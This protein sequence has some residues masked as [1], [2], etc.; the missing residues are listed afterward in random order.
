[1]DLF[2]NAVCRVCD[3]AQV[4]I[5][6][7]I[8]FSDPFPSSGRP[9]HGRENMSV[10]LRL[11][12][13]VTA[14]VCGLALSLCIEPS[15][16]TAQSVGVFQRDDCTTITSPVTG[17]TYCYDQTANTLKKWNGV[18][19]VGIANERHAYRVVDD[20][21]RFDGVEVADAA[22][23]SGKATVI[24]AT[25]SC[26]VADANRV[27]WVYGAG[28]GNS[29]LST[30]VSSCS[31]PAF[32]LATRASTTVTNARFIYGSDDTAAIQTTLNRLVQG[33]DK[34]NLNVELPGGITFI[35]AGLS[36]ANSVS[37]LTLYGAG[38]AGTKIYWNGAADATM[39]LLQR[40]RNVTVRDFSLHGKSTAIPKYG[41]EVRGLNG[42]PPGPGAIGTPAPQYVIIDGMWIGSM[43][44][45]SIQRAV[46]W[47]PGGLK[48][49]TDG[50]MISGSRN[51]ESSKIGFTASD[52]GK[53]CTVPG[54]LRGARLA[55]YIS[56]YVSSSRVVLS[57]PAS[58]TVTGKNIQCSWDANNERGI[59]RNS[60]LQGT[61][62]GL[63]FE[64][65]NSRWHVID[66]S[67]VGGGTAGVSNIGPLGLEGGSFS[68]INTI[69]GSGSATGYLF[70]IGPAEDQIHVIN[71][72]AED[73]NSGGLLKFDYTQDSTAGSILFTGGSYVVGGRSLT[74][75]AN[76]GMTDHSVLWNAKAGRLTFNATNIFAPHGVTHCYPS[77]VTN[78]HDGV[79]INGGMQ[80]VRV[81]KA[82]LQV[83]V[84]SLSMHSP[85]TFSALS[86]SGQ[87]VNR[88]N[89][90]Q[91]YSGAAPITVTN[92][93][94]IDVSA[95][96]SVYQ[97]AY[98]ASTTVGRMTGGR[99][100]QVVTLCGNPGAATNVILRA[101]HATD[102]IEIPD[103]PA[104]LLSGQ[105]R[106]FVRSGA[107]FGSR[108]YEMNL[109]ISHSLKWA[110]ALSVSD[111]GR[112]SHG[113]GTR[114]TACFTQS[115]VAGEFA[116]VA[117]IS[118]TDV[119][120]AVKKYDGTA[121]T[122]QTVYWLCM[123]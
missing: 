77:T 99:P 54:A 62:Y 104:V 29:L 119:I 33:T 98:G 46:G 89:F 59:I 61:G 30:T 106:S 71:G 86:A 3:G 63:S 109:G 97:L 57:Q 96:A 122:P 50:T 21:A 115:T 6:C 16:A 121:G 116:A 112:V 120:V 94:T 65:L 47:T 88:D 118:G 28:A 19:W 111:G 82:N 105:C 117:G 74:C 8:E 113:M 101:D 27:A 87:L 93:N 37:N 52:V 10:F 100:G 81:I 25:A 41:V 11:R 73:P 12:A 14:C 92:G 80:N 34:A 78:S 13:F 108:W 39:L 5:G 67:S 55:A 85:F 53:W 36:T 95:G 75:A 15:P 107:E 66:S 31:G 84:S 83:S 60:T 68:A 110:A 51:L 7:V 35:S 56:S 45:E 91:A 42:N 58:T 76:S 4:L 72:N 70:E 24:S 18:A 43:F 20:G 32:V 17:K 2:W 123:K 64:H 26:G 22:I 38:L 48:T 23:D 40:A 49:A 90:D 103:T 69:F 44:G 114:P 102:S 9:A 1:V 79:F